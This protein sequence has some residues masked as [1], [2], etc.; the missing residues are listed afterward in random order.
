MCLSDE[1]FLL[2]RSIRKSLDYLIKKNTLLTVEVFNLRITVT[3]HSYLSLKGLQDH[4]DTREYLRF[5]LMFDLS[6]EF[7][8]KSDVRFF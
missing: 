8:E 4:V 3:T 1:S 7:M 5:K 6:L 2:K